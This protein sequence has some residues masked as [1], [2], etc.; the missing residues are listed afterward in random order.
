[1]LF[2][3]TSYRPYA[4]LLMP[5]MG[6]CLQKEVAPIPPD[7]PSLE[8]GEQTVTTEIVTP[9]TA[10][11]QLTLNNTGKVD[12]EYQIDTR[13]VDSIK[14]SPSQGTLNSGLSS[15]LNV[16]LT[17][18]TTGTS[19]ENIEV[20]GP[21]GMTL[22][23]VAIE[24]VCV[25]EP[26]PEI[27]ELSP[28]TFQLN[29][30]V[31][32][33][34]N[35]EFS[36]SNDGDA[37]LIYTV[38]SQASWIGVEPSQGTLTPGSTAEVSIDA[39]CP[40]E[41]A[42]AVG[43]IVVRS[44]DEDEA[45]KSVNVTLDC[46][47]LPTAS[48]TGP[49]P[50][51]FDT[52]ILVD[53]TGRSAFSFGNDGPGQL[54]YLLGAD[55][56]WLTVDSALTGSVN[57]GNMVD[58]SFAVRCGATETTRQGEIEIESNDPDDPVT[59]F[60]VRVQCNRPDEPEISEFEP[61]S[62]S[63]SA[64]LNDS[65]AGS[66]SFSNQGAADLTYS[67]AVSDAW[68]SL[69]STASGTL[70]QGQ[71]ISINLEAVCEG[72]V[73]TRN[74]RITV[75]TN[76]SDEPT[77]VLDV[78]LSCGGLANMTLERVYFT[79][80]VPAA[81]S[82]QSPSE[83]I[84]IVA[85]RAALL[86]AFVSST[87]SGLTTEVSL[88][89][90]SG[91]GNETVIP[92]NSPTSLSNNPRESEISDTFNALLDA[93]ELTVGTEFYVEVDPENKVNESDESDNR[94]P[95]SGYEALDVA[96]LATLKVHFVPIDTNGRV[97]DPIDAMSYLKDTL[98]TLPVGNIEA[99]V[100]SAPLVVTD[101][102]GNP[103]DVLDDVDILREADGNNGSGIFY[104]AIIQRGPGGGIV[105][106]AYTPGYVGAGLSASDRGID[107]TRET[108][109]HELGHNFSLPHA[110]CG[111]PR[112]PDPNF[113]YS[114]GS[115]GVWGHNVFTGD[116]FSPAGRVKD[117]MTYC[118]PVWISDYNFDKII[119]RRLS[120][121]ARVQ[122]PSAASRSLMVRGSIENGQVRIETVIEI[123]Q[124]PS[125]P[126]PGQYEL[127]VYDQS[128]GEPMRVS[129]DAKELD[130][131][132]VQH[133]L[134]RVPVADNL[135]TMLQVEKRG[136]L[137]AERRASSRGSASAKPG[138]T[139]ATLESD[140]RV[141]LVWDKTAYQTAIIRAGVGGDVVAIDRSGTVVFRSASDVIS[142]T[143][144]DGLNSFKK[145]VQIR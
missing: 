139:E 85:N 55:Q 95:N 62:L 91:S 92:L 127:V 44:N 28:S 70:A 17:C 99:D 108:T 103:C 31:N 10:S 111:G 90:R 105:G 72:R 121:D 27:S 63:L 54:T 86:R 16:T 22:D 53:T 3:K 26:V 89:L 64:P 100:R 41:P 58:V 128:G 61:T 96:Q 40:A 97:P 78:V 11:F 141:R 123:E 47:S 140:G 82:D 14:F 56:S 129:F 9:G 48:I 125:V 109:A 73:E 107:D 80:S 134:V 35:E 102:V 79:Q 15:T 132:T 57:P 8:F 30:F 18:S 113:P 19:T 118:N 52:E 13:G 21:D 115:I 1:M 110:P 74:G 145:V 38:A 32:A 25:P 101:G 20:L 76:D 45:E 112:G 68:I 2:G 138:V 5:L 50:D 136:Q 51:R 135:L 93:G 24:L 39:Q 130:H 12:T 83:R 142:V 143:L 98:E 120:T 36:F 59:R 126:Q 65:S 43:T 87:D 104:Y 106:C 6:G 119:R 84:A 37:D 117:L 71:G 88:V 94:Y 49:V 69:V 144:S 67:A 75:S 133:F 42:Q 34:A 33:T 7:P 66:F 77:K 137:M 114:D 116:S 81:D 29:A 122:R 124:P 46:E 131:S 23:T 4:I 60:P